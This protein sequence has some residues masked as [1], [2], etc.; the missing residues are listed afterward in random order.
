MAK[1]GLD[2]IVVGLVNSL[3]GQMDTSLVNDLQ[4]RLHSGP[5]SPFIDLAAF[6]INRGR[7]HGI[8]SYTKY[9]SMC[10]GLAL[11]D[12]NDLRKLNWKGSSVSQV[13]SLYR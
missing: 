12:F 13:S 10:T 4:N 2:S 11:S 9:A 1:G 6:N 3:S 7:D 5:G 8:P